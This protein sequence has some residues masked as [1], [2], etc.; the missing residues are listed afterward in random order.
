MRR[1]RSTSRR[2]LPRGQP[3]SKAHW[4]SPAGRQLEGADKFR[5][6]DID[7]GHPGPY[8]DFNGITSKYGAHFILRI[9]KILMKE[10]YYDAVVNGVTLITDEHVKIINDKLRAEKER[11]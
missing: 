5:A 4:R 3:S 11:R 6:E 2:T 1:T 9:D 7:D 8:N 10:R